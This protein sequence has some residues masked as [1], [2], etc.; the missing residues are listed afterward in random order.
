MAGNGDVLVFAYDIVTPDG[1]ADAPV[2]TWEP[3]MARREFFAQHIAVPLGVAHRRHWI[4]KVGGFN[5]LSWWEED[6]DLWRRFARAGAD[7][8]FVPVKSGRYYVYADSGSRAP[9]LTRRQRET[10][11]ANRLAGRPLYGPAVP[12]PSGR[13]V[14]KIAFISPHCVIDYTNGAATATLDGLDFVQSLG[15][16]C[17]AFSSSRLD[18]WEEVLIEEVLC[19][20][21]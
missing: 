9:R 2:R 11:E 7:F 10:F 18:A 16:V 3:V 14:R 8:A 4:E 13:Q 12:L 20:G 21:A 17:E 6:T 1:S 15:F 5:E 19:S